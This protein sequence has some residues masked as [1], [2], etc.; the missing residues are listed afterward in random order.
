MTRRLTAAAIAILATVLAVFAVVRGITNEQVMRGLLEADLDRE[1]Q[2]I[3]VALNQGAGTTTPIDPTPYADADYRVRV[4]LPDGRA[5]TAGGERVDEAEGQLVGSGTW[6]GLT[7]ELTAT[8]DALDAATRSAWIALVLL[9]LALATLGAVAFALVVR[10]ITS[11]LVVLAEA[12]NALRRGRLQLQLPSSSVP[13]ITA[14]TDALAASSRRLQETLHR[15]RDLALRAAH[16]VRTPLTTLGLELDELATRDD[17][18]DDA[19]ATAARGRDRVTAATQAL[20]LVLKEVRSHQVAP[21]SEV[22]L[23]ELAAAAA[24]AWGATLEADDTEVEVVLTGDP[25]AGITAGPF[26]Q[27]LDDLLLA[28]RAARVSPVQLALRGGPEH[29]R[30]AVSGD[31][32]ATPTGAAAASVD[33]HLDRVRQLTDTLGGRVSGTWG[34]RDGVVVLVP[35]R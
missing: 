8:D 32:S 2:T 6:D 25:S 11:A 27:L 35:R 19:I 30:I 34:A 23:S 29:V 4:T 5:V 12:A 10:P 20:E 24:V 15:D 18:P 7:V 9:A 13:E 22:S 16:E 14:L 17:L 21:E 1:A 28:V 26:E 3:A 31:A 33:Q